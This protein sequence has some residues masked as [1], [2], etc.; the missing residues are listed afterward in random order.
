MNPTSK[1]QVKDG[2]FCEVVNGRHAGKSGTIS[3]INTSKSGHVS[4][5]VEQKDGVRFKTL[6]K[7]VVVK[8]KATT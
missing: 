3:D 4:I 7:D 5:S 1:S 8:P 6:A 2:D